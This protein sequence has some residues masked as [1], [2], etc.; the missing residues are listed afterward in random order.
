M[1]VYRV[2]MRWAMGPWGDCQAA[3]TAA[4]CR[5][6]SR[7]ILNL[8][9]RLLQP[10]GHAHLPVHRHRG[11]E[12]FTG[13]LSLVC[14][15]VELAATQMTVG[16]QGTHPTLGGQCRRIEERALCPDHVQRLA[17][18]RNLALN[19]ET[20]RL[21]TSLALLAAEREG[22]DGVVTGA[23]DVTCLQ[24][25]FGQRGDHN[26]VTVSER[27]RCVMC[28][29]PFQ[30]CDRFEKSAREGVCTAEGRG[31]PR[32]VR[33]KIAAGLAEREGVLEDLDGPHVIALH[34]T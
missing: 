24:S 11:G 31:R 18:Q 29:G 8:R 15:A 22:A 2:A 30:E 17:A 25:R 34:E 32:E 4:G 28:V 21:P 6:S 3:R 19:A 7:Q 12:V 16:R 13:L 20:P 26:R 5:R 9:F 33:G 1:L 10:V 27:D 14:T 23:L